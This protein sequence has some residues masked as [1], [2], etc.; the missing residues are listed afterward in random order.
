MAGI[1]Q[2]CQAVREQSA[3]KFEN[4]N[5]GRNEQ[6]NRQ[7]FLVVRSVM[8]M[9]DSVRVIVPVTVRMG[10]VAVVGMIMAVIVMIMIMNVVMVMIVVVRMSPV[11]GFGFILLVVSHLLLLQ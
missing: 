2:Q 11:C 7:A 3:E 5:A 4:H 1:G 10:V 8:V 6:G 9:T